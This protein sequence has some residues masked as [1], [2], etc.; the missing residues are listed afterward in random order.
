MS[1]ALSIADFMGDR[2]VDLFLL[3]I[4]S[5]GSVQYDIVPARETTF[6]LELRT[7]VIIYSREAQRS[8]A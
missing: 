3:R 7:E 6:R 8:A 2:N 4:R 1:V 5:M